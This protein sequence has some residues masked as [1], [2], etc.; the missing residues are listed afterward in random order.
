MKIEVLVIGGG[1]VGL[2]CAAESAKNGFS[3][4]LVERHESFGQETSSRN[5]EV[6]HSGIY[7][8]PGSL[9]AKLCVT[10]NHNLY[11]ECE[12]SGVWTKRCGKLIVAVTQEER[13]PLEELYKRGLANGVGELVLLDAIQA[14]RIE[15]YIKCC[16]AIYVLSTGIIDSHQLMKS[17]LSEAKSFGADFAFNVNFVGGERKNYLFDVRLRDTDGHLTTLEAEYV[18][19]AAGLQSDKVAQAFG[20]N[21]DTAGYRLHYNR[22]HYY[23]VSPSKGKLISHLVYPIPLK[24]LVSVGIHTAIDKAGRVR[25]GPDHEYLDQSIPEIDW[26]KFDDTRK[27][28]FLKAVQ[29]YFPALQLSDLSPD[30]VGVRPKLKGSESEVKDF[31]IQEESVKGLSG[32]VNLIGIESPGLTCAREIAREVIRRIVDIS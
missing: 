18:I 32:L 26:Y 11:K 10:A 9:K 20:I 19:N 31:I 14:K 8:Q 1:I 12:R 3:T 28:K 4:L 27:E 16:A 30:Q 25:L 24:H 29:S 6:I 22:G 2:S 21:I 17:Y 5:S 15:P 13:K 7:Y 23:S